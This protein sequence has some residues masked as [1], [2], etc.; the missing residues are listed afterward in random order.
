MLHYGQGDGDDVHQKGADHDGVHHGKV[1]GLAIAEM[2]VVILQNL[3]LG[4]RGSANILSVVYV[5]VLNCFVECDCHD[6][7]FVSVLWEQ[8]KTPACCSRSAGVGSNL[9]SVIVSG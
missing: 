3:G 2:V 9:A 5:T 4:D 1:L 6:V 7:S 8:N